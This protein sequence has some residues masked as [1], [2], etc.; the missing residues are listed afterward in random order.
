MFTL[1]HASEVRAMSAIDEL[2]AVPASINPEEVKLAGQVIVGRYAGTDRAPAAASRATG[3]KSGGTG[4]A[5]RYP[6]E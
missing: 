3:A 2:K 6:C 5:G 1:R 4:S